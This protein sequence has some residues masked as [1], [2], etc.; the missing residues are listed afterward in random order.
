MHTNESPKE[1][2]PFES[3]KK[4]WPLLLV[5]IV[6]DVIFW[7]CFPQLESATR[8]YPIADTVS[9]VLF[10][11]VIGLFVE[12]VMSGMTLWASLRARLLGTVLNLLTGSL[13]GLWEK[14]VV[15]TYL[16]PRFIALV[17]LT[18][19]AS[20]QLTA[21]MTIGTWIVGFLAF[22]TFQIPLYAVNLWCTERDWKKRLRAVMS[23][24][25]IFVPL[26]WLYS[27]FNTLLRHLIAR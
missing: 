13:N 2:T 1:L 7:L 15:A 19:I 24:M 26:A 14:K 10:S 5:A 17:G 6:A 4:C 18:N 16:A 23:M 21:S 8:L 25:L 27:P 22:L 9:M 11:L 20:Y 12:V 3:L